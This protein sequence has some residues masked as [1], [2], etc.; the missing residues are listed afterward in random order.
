MTRLAAGMS[1]RGND[2]AGACSLSA[3][4]PEESV[5]RMSLARERADAVSW[6]RK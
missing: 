3:C 2:L 4:T 6:P 5:A 1:L